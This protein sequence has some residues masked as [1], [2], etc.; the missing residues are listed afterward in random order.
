MAP[1]PEEELTFSS[2]TERAA[3]AELSEEIMRARIEEFLQ[4]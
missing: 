2:A 4:R 3:R 1:E